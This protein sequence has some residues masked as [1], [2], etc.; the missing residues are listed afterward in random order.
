MIR[1]PIPKII[2]RFFAQRKAYRQRIAQ[3]LASSSASG[4]PLSDDGWRRL[5]PDREESQYHWIKPRPFSSRWGTQS[6][7]A[8]PRLPSEKRL[9][10]AIEKSFRG[11][12]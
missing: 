7:T 12:K 8:D 2:L 4:Q 6:Q 3:H 1:L 11:R 9:Q 10:E 5:H